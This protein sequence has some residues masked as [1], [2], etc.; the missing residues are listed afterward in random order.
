MKKSKKSSVRRPERS[1]DPNQLDLFKGVSLSNGG[2]PCPVDG[3][4]S[5]MPGVLVADYSHLVFT[6]SLMDWAEARSEQDSVRDRM[7]EVIR[8]RPNL[9]YQL[10]TKRQENIERYLPADCVL[11]RAEQK[12]TTVAE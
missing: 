6:R 12:C 4:S 9:H 1:R 10:L 8:K 11:S 3:A 5:S 7:E 2:A